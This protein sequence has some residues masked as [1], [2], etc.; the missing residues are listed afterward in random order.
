MGEGGVAA[1]SK[2]SCV[3]NLLQISVLS[4]QCKAVS[5]FTEPIMGRR[6]ADEQKHTCFCA[7]SYRHVP[8][9]A[10]RAGTRKVQMAMHV[11]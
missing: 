5:L 2:G 10:T 7:Y 8:N 6:K 3:V 9:M 1:R 11:M 4:A